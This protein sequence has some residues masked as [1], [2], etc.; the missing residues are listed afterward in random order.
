[1]KNYFF[2]LGVC[3]MLGSCSLEDTTASNTLEDNSQEDS[4]QEDDSREGSSKEGSSK[5][6]SSQEGSSEEDKLQDDSSQAPAFI[7]CRAVS[8]NEIEFEFSKP[9]MVKTLSFEPALV[10]SS[11][12]DGSTVTVLLEENAAP[13]AL[14]TVDLLAEDEHGNSINVSTSFRSRNSRMPEL[15]INELCTEYAN[16]KSGKKAE[17]IELKMKSDGNLG[18]MRIFIMGNT[19]VAKLTIHEFM[20]VEVK[21]DEYVVLHLRTFSELSKDE[22]GGSLDESG[23]TNS[24]PTARDFWLPGNSKLI[25]KAAATVYVLDQDDNVLDAV[26]LSTSSNSWWAKDYFANAAEFLFQ[27]DA[28]KTTDGK[29]CGPEYAVNSNGTT[30]TRTICRDETAEDSNTAADWYITATSSATP[31]RVNSDKRYR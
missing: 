20:P 12:K 9:V 28:W 1:M 6:D 27:Q 8:E 5:E 16:N 30:N 11:I 29:I 2:L 13:G 4:F 17:F 7:N 15:A 14:V 25:Q 24:S 21:K 3:I 26:M 19:N 22:Y 31:G 10:V 18:G 23:G